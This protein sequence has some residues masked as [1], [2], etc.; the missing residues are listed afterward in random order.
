MR[1]ILG[2]LFCTVAFAHPLSQALV[3]PSRP[4]PLIRLLQITLLA[5]PVHGVDVPGRNVELQAGEGDASRP[6]G[7]SARRDTGSSAFNTMFDNAR[8][9]IGGHKVLGSFTQE[10]LQG[11]TNH[12]NGKVLGS[13]TQEDLQGGTNHEN[14]K[15]GGEQSES[16]TMVAKDATTFGPPKVHPDEEKVITPGQ[17]LTPEQN[18][19]ELEEYVKRLE[20]RSSKEAQ[21]VRTKQPRRA[22]ARTPFLNLAETYA[23]LADAQEKFRLF[24]QKKKEEAAAEAAALSIQTKQRR[25]AARIALKR[26]QSR[27][28]EMQQRARLMAIYQQ[29]KQPE[30]APKKVPAQRVAQPSAKQQEILEKQAIITGGCSISTMRWVQKF[31]I[32]RHTAAVT[33]QARVR[34]V[35]AKRARRLA[36]K[37]SAGSGSG[38]V[39]GWRRGS[40]AGRRAAGLPA[41]PAHLRPAAL[42]GR[43]RADVPRQDEAAETDLAKDGLRLY[44]SHYSNDKGNIDPR[45]T[46]D[47]AKKEYEDGAVR[48]EYLR[49]P[50]RRADGLVLPYRENELR[51][52]KEEKYKSLLRILTSGQGIVDELVKDLQEVRDYLAWHE[53]AGSAA[54]APSFVKFAHSSSVFDHRPFIGDYDANPADNFGNNA[55]FSMVGS[56]EKWMQRIKN[57]KTAAVA[58]L[59][60]EQ[61]TNPNWD[62]LQSKAAAL[63]IQVQAVR[64]EVVKYFDG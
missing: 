7:H 49:A 22:A 32:R 23:E 33:I 12:E 43:K 51:L 60:T 55:K 20:A 45:M 25:H 35:L 34:G 17:N 41:T 19:K 62:E 16:A 37:V 59:Q 53:K 52:V 9:F 6:S 46:P 28:R 18:L 48:E 27:E 54:C 50:Q 63:L 1:S 31:K 8:A 4:F 21:P 42:P 61:T 38:V 24:D 57:E 15:V 2:T 44:L 30:P 3:L 39:T 26:V 56:F 58:K 29:R 10:D 36:T 64:A 47:E 11:G 14:G 13:F 5:G 40:G